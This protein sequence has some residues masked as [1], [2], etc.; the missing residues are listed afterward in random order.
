MLKP[1]T[2]TLTYSITHTDSYSVGN[3]RFFLEVRCWRR[4]CEQSNPYSDK[5]KKA[6][7]QTCIPLYT[8]MKCRWIIVFNL[9]YTISGPEMQLE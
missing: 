1:S 3:G 6:W 9:K 4:Q 2:R 8:T 5:V 7:S